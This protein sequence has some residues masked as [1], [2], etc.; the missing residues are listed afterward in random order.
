M[1][2]RK[3]SEKENLELISKMIRNTKEDLNSRDWNIFLIMGYSAFILSV[4]IYVLLRL[5]HIYQFSLLWL[6]MFV[7][8]FITR[9][10]KR[11]NRPDVI[12]YTGKMI[13]QTWRI[14]GSLFGI[15]FIVL[16][17]SVF[18]MNYVDF[19][20]MMPLSLIYA[21]IGTAIT[22]LVIK[23]KSLVFTPIVGFVIAIY[24]LIAL[25]Q[26][27]QMELIWNLYLGISFFIMMVIPIHILNKK[28]K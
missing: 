28:I 21:C 10:Y 5:T 2:N 18:F 20:L 17:L 16:S 7:A 6:L 23:E 11:K 19:G 27:Q 22:G 8:A 4:L 3:L 25:V 9:I 1:D 24:M 26:N 14:I 13:I 15:T 12:S